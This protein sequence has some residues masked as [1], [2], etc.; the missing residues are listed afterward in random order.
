MRRLYL[1]IYATVL[2]VILLFGV[3]MSMVWWMAVREGQGP[4]MLA[5]LGELAEVVLPADGVSPDDQQRRLADLAAPFDADAALF[6]AA[7]RQL[8]SV[9]AAVPPPNTDLD[10]PRRWGRHPGHERGVVSLELPDGR[11]LVARIP[12]PDRERHGGMLLAILLLA[13]ATG[14]GSYPVVRRLTRRLEAFEGKVEELGRGDLGARMPVQGRDEV[15]RLAER[16]NWTAERIET[17]VEEK[18]KALAT[19]SHELRTPLARIRVAIELMEAPGRPELKERVERDIGELDGLIGE[20]L[21]NSRLDSPELALEPEDLDLLALTAEVCAPYEVE[22]EGESVLVE[23]EAR[24][25][26][27]LIQNLL[28]NARRYA[29]G[30]NAASVR[31]GADGDC[32]LTVCDGGPGVP[33][34]ERERI[35]EPFYRPTSP[36]EQSREHTG[37]AGPSDSTQG[38]GGLGL[39]LV[40]QIAERHG[41]S[42]RCLAAEGGGTCFEVRLPARQP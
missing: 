26:R 30:A 13:L 9:G 16:F 22:A 14:L 42:V 27:R 28:E 36:P 12:D 31:R 39:A 38:E 24:L 34:D 37:E 21:M 41:G 3:L 33:P 40:R 11:W 7:G 29:G 35:F 2:G 4:E 5:R 18:K 8:A 25:L 19:V 32:V 15:A 10:S 20:L 1:Q 23:G 17:L 6:D